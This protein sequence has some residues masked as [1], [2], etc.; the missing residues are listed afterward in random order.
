MPPPPP[1][2]RPRGGSI[3]GSMNETDLPSEPSTRRASDPD[4][5]G[6]LPYITFMFMSTPNP[7]PFRL[8][9]SHIFRSDNQVSPKRDTVSVHSHCEFPSFHV[10]KCACSGPGEYGLVWKADLPSKCCSAKPLRK[11]PKITQQKSAHIRVLVQVKCPAR[12]VHCKTRDFA[13]H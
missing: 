3:T 8:P 10:G 4:G 11:S 5:V 13:T 6:P 7:A 12:T 9:F 1:M 2:G